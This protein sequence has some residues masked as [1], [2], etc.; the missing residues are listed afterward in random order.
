VNNIDNPFSVETPESM[1]AQE[2][3]D[4]FVPLQEYYDLS[5]SGH[6]FLHGHRGSGKSMMFRRLSPDCQS[7]FHN[8]E[9]NQLDFFGVYASMK[10]TDLDLMDLS[11][12]ES[13]NAKS[14][15]SEHVLICFFLSKIFAEIRTHFDFST[16]EEKKALQFFFTDKLIPIFEGLG[17][18]KELDKSKYN[19]KNGVE[20]LNYIVSLFDNYY[21]SY[22]SFLK[23]LLT[24]FG[25]QV[26]YSGPLFSFYDL[27]LPIIEE[28][29]TMSFM[30]TGPI[31]LLVDDVDNLNLSQTKVINSW[32]SYRTT[33]I[34]SFKLATQMNYKTLVT[35]S[36]RRIEYPH[37]FKEINY[38]SVYTGSKKDK[39]PEWVKEVTRKRL[40][41]FY[42]NKFG[43]DDI[44]I[45]PESY[46]P[47]D[48][49]QQLAIE[50]LANKYKSG[51]IEVRG[52]R[53]SDDSYRY[54]RP[55]YIVSLGGNSKNS[56]TYKYAGFNQLVHLSSGII[57][58]FLDPASKMYSLQERH[59]KE[60]VF[61]E[62]SPTYQN[63]VLRDEADNLLF[64]QI[65]NMIEECVNDE[66]EVNSSIK[67][68]SIEKL[69]NLISAMGALFYSAMK[70][71]NSERRFFSFAL[72]DPEK[73]SKELR[74]VLILGVQ[75]G[76]LYQS[77]VGT[78]EGMGRTKLYVLTR[79]LAPVFK[80]DPIGFS[81]YKFV[82]CKFLEE[83]MMHPKSLINIMKN[84]GL[85]GIE[86]RFEPAQRSLI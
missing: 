46:F 74:R 67:L 86:E 47:F 3:N 16:D 5:V 52:F 65:D 31:F 25:Q 59:S 22:V 70:S 64:S 17:Y 37:D 34:L 68:D 20:L 39:Y 44:D 12:I 84:K 56:S 41:F 69:R 45:D 28:I 60:D 75:E 81:A 14:V 4:L 36:G 61:F 9:I 23:K 13:T 2:I 42:K 11:A 73:M 43:L 66:D 77:Y 55:D 54:A 71:N 49:K 6:V 29:K 50:N 33:D 78:K 8:K 38:S 79:R 53:A 80:L 57:R 27:F 32:V 10:K 18:G 48:E 19:D 7:L 72:S 51:E 30:P 26:N 83:S 63:S 1:S 35:V 40:N 82:T 21:K 85:D 15:I 76:Y 24:S 62:I 58:Y